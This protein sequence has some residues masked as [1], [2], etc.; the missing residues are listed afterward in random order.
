[1]RHVF[2]YA[3]IRD[4][5]AQVDRCRAAPVPLIRTASGAYSRCI[6]TGELRQI[7]ALLDR[8]ELEVLDR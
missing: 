8:S 1:V 3:E 6:R 4:G 2:L 5:E 7:G